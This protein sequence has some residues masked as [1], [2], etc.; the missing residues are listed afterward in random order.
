LWVFALPFVLTWNIR[1]VLLEAPGA[2]RTGCAVGDD[3]IAAALEE[4]R[5]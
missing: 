5:A 3:A 4:L 2:V 1:Y